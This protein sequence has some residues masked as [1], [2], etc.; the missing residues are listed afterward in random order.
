MKKLVSVILTSIILL[1]CASTVK[2]SIAERSTATN[3]IQQNNRM[4]SYSG[5]INI[6]ILDPD[7]TNNEI[8]IITEK[9]NG[10]VTRSGTDFSIVRIPS[11]KTNDFINEIKTYG[12]IRNKNISGMDITDEYN[13]ILIKIDSL[14]RL[15]N[16]YTNLIGKAV[17]VQ[18]MLAIEKELER[19]NHELE[20][21]EGQKLKSE[22]M[23]E[24]TTITIYYHKKVTPGPIG[25]IF[26]GLYSV[27][28]WLFIWG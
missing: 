6:E 18:D 14:N 20:L 23:V 4:I 8:N 13:D 27:I 25:W 7:K 5:S 10:F 2:S 15:R 28:R 11:D 9:L 1:G 22:K 3:G 26:Y 17:N 21:L 24:Y 12:K 19:V 16:K